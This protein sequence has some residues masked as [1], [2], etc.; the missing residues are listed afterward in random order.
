MELDN[1]K[2]A[3]IALDNRL[4]KDE[5]L[6][7]SII[8]E[9]IQTKANKL[10]NKLMNW[11]VFG[12]VIALL[13][14]PFSV[15]MFNLFGGKFPMWDIL[16]LFVIIVGI[17]LFIWQLYKICGLMKVD[18]SRSIRDN[19]YYM[20]QYNIRMKREK[21][22]MGF[23][24]GPILAI[25]SVITYASMKASFA[26]WIFLLFAIIFTTLASF[27]QYKRLYGKNID[28]IIKSLDEIRELKEE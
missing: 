5:E 12:A 17:V 7:E 8:L 26:F 14:T 9:M 11:E 23:I 25:L 28:S 22:I 1:L 10:I 18:L 21:V 19:T 24:V 2:E 13:T 20:N 6:K 27:W 4:K 3:W 15:I 16:V